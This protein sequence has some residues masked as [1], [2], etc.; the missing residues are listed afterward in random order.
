MKSAT[1][2]SRVL[3][4]TISLFLSI[5]V[6]ELGHAFIGRKY[7]AVPV[8]HLHGLGGLTA[9]PGMRFSRRQHIAVTAAGPA[10]SFA[11]AGRPS[12]C[13]HHSA[14]VAASRPAARYLLVRDQF[15]FDVPQFAPHSAFGWRTNFARHSR[16]QAKG[17]H[18]MDRRFLCRRSCSVGVLNWTN[19]PRHLVGLFGIPQ[20]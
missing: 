6:H 10:A 3:L 18:S 11:L 19:L 14:N 13:L 5:L 9:F 4:W 8:I 2:F 12:V 17:S 16:S 20:L 7:G 1:D 15:L